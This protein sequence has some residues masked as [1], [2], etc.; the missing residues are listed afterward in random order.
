MGSECLKTEQ[1]AALPCTCV[2]APGTKAGNMARDFSCACWKHGTNPCLMIPWEALLQGGVQHLAMWGWRGKVWPGFPLSLLW[3]GGRFFSKEVRLLLASVT[4]GIRFMDS[5]I[6]PD[7][8][9][10]GRCLNNLWADGRV[11]WYFYMS[12]LQKFWR[13][14][15]LGS[16]CQHFTQ[17]PTEWAVPV[18]KLED[19]QVLELLNDLSKNHRGVQKGIWTLKDWN[20]NSD[21]FQKLKSIYI[22]L[23]WGNVEGSQALIGSFTGFPQ[24]LKWELL[25]I[26]SNLTMDECKWSGHEIQ[27]HFRDCLWLLHS[28]QESDW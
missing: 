6:L 9:V 17:I 5:F 7:S 22:H 1:R 23:H 8:S 12:H 25:L 28:A 4:V 13:C 18:F 16:A 2:P 15:L 26:S 3:Y 19:G 27:T 24:S 11:W 21:F 10:H 20:S 14:L